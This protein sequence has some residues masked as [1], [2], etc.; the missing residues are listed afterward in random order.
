MFNAGLFSG[1]FDQTREPGLLPDDVLFR[2]IPVAY[3]AV[4]VAVVYLGWLSDRADIRGAAA[5]AVFG[6][7]SGLVVASVGIVTMWTAIDMTGLFVAAGALVQVSMLIAAGA[8]LGAYRADGD[9]RR[10]TQRV[11]LFAFLAA[12]AGIVAQ[13]VLR[14]QQ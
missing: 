5:G 14:G 4:G 12:L 9:H 3:L 1:L 8:V 2:R 11:L 10:L 13:N 7:I 6:A